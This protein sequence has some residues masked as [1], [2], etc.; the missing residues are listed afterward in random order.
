MNSSTISSRLKTLIESLGLSDSQFAD[1]CH[2]SRATLSLLLSGKNKKVS[3]ILLSNIHNTF[4]NVSIM[5]LLFGEGEIFAKSNDDDRKTV[6]SEL[7][8]MDK[9]GLFDI[10]DFEN[11]E[12]SNLADIKSIVTI[13]QS[14]VDKAIEDNFVNLEQRIKKDE[15]KISERQIT[16][17]TIYY[18]DSTYVTFFPGK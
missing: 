17:V 5:W 12:N 15:E 3:D 2:I 4:P 7:S 11:F 13:L 6:S 1:Q 9:N 10:P 14:S 8:N 18:D 16:H